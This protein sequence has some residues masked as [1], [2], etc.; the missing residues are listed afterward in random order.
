MDFVDHEYNL[1]IRRAGYEIIFVPASIN[2]HEIGKP[3]VI[4]PRIIRAVAHLTT[5]GPLG[6]EAP[7]RQYY[8]VRN[9]VYTFWHEFRNYRALFFCALGLVRMIVGMFLFSDKDKAKRIK[10]VALGLRD[11]FGGRLGTTV[12]PS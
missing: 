4:K 1:R 5:R 8:M 6:I 9:E 12:T 7:W 2:Y 11:G 10:Y 3:R